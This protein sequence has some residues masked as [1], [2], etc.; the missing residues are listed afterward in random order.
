MYS[1]WFEWCSVVLVSIQVIVMLPLITFLS[2]QYCKNFT[3]NRLFFKQ[4]IVDLNIV[5]T[6]LMIIIFHLIVPYF[7][8]VTVIL[9]DYNFFMKF[10]S[11]QWIIKHETM[12]VDYSIDIIHLI[13]LLYI[14]R[15]GI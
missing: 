7:L 9:K 13:E 2:I 14:C 12:I 1:S 8:L 15:F 4:R 6:I 5:F 11:S 3:S 10:E